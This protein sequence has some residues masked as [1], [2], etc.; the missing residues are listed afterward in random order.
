MVALDVAVLV[1]VALLAVLVAG[2]L[3]SHAEVIRALHQMGVDLSPT[4]ASAIGSMPVDFAPRPTPARPHASDTVD[5]AG[6]TPTGEVVSIAVRSVRHDTLI[7]FLTSGCVTCRS[8][9]DAFRSGAPDIPGGARLV[10][11]TRGAEAESPG[12]VAELGGTRLPIVMSTELWERYDVP[13]A[14]Y[15][16]YISGPA[17]KVV[18][19]GTAQTWAQV[20]ALVTNAVVDGTTSP[21]GKARADSQREDRIDHELSGVGIYPGDPRL[22]PT[23]IRDGE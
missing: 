22:H 11:V 13:A 12:T 3:R 20:S 8:F 4:A 21:H 7:A 6:A 16:T 23:T 19:E 10:V 17:A 1:V 2:L 18:G 9:W 15:F 14:P 5:L